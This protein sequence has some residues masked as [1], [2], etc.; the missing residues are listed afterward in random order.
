MHDNIYNIPASAAA[1]G[2]V[3]T[4]NAFHYI[5]LVFDGTATGNANRLKVYVNGSLATLSFTGT[6]P[7]NTENGSP[8][9][10]IGSNVV[11][12]VAGTVVEVGAVGRTISGTEITNLNSYLA[13]RYG[14]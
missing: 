9:P 11:S 12:S 13:T 10:S 4:T 5:L 1:Y 7:T 8:I 6:I 14:L 2:S 3:G